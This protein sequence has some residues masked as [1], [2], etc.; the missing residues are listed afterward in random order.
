MIEFV[1]VVIGLA[2][3]SFVNA[4]VW[5]LH[6]QAGSARSNK[7]TELSILRGRSLCPSCKHRLAVLDLVPVLS[8]LG[9]RGRCRYCKKLISTQYPCVELLTAILFVVS[10]IFWPYDLSSNLSAWLLFVSFL[11]L[12]VLGVAMSLYDLKW[13]ILPNKLVYS[14]GLFAVIWWLLLAI[15]QQSTSFL[16][17]GIIGSFGFGGFFY[18]LYQISGGKWIGGGDVRLGA[19]LGLILGWQRSIVALALAAYAAT[20]VVFVLVLLR[21]YH[22]KM[23]IPFGPFLLI[24]TLVAVL[25]GQ[26]VIDWY[27]RLSGLTS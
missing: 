4:L 21:K 14:F 23:H 10:Y 2:F 5:R 12:T 17:S 8:W 26:S 3:G 1:L 22:K 20:A 15:S 11:P 16:M 9:L 19:M 13:M 6:E 27:T 7:N 25:W 24:A 18:V